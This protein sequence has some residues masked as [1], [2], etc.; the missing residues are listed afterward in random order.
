[1]GMVQCRN[2]GNT[3]LR[4]QN[5]STVAITGIPESPAK[6]ARTE[7]GHC[8]SPGKTLPIALDALG[9]HQVESSRVHERVEKSKG[10][11]MYAN[12]ILAMY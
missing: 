3:R 1:M 8:P 7:V 9:H 10:R 4:A 2:D 12:V 6:A 5:L 11:E